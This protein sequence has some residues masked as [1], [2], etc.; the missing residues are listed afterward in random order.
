MAATQIKVGTS[1]WMA[2]NGHPGYGA[3]F[4]RRVA[5]TMETYGCSM[6]DAVYGGR[7]LALAIEAKNPVAS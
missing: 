2:A 7:G 6:H 1:R 5:R 3:A 4:A